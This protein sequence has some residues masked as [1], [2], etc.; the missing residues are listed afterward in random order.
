M[1]NKGKNHCRKDEKKNWKRALFLQPKWRRSSWVWS[2]RSAGYLVIVHCRYL[3]S[4]SI[5]TDHMQTA[6]HTP[7]SLLLRYVRSLSSSFM[8]FDF[9]LNSKIHQLIFLFLLW[10]LL[11]LYGISRFLYIIYFS[12][13]ICQSM[14]RCFFICDRTKCYKLAQ[15]GQYLF[16]WF[17]SPIRSKSFQIIIMY[18]MLSMCS[19]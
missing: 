6:K 1:I 15:L 8:L 13:W 4:R 18:P 9:I 19:P 7:I 12:W 11:E 17:W 10:N 5:T 16:R 2:V 3:F 14:A